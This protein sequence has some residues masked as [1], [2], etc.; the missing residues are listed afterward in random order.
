MQGKARVDSQ[1][2]YHQARRRTFLLV[3]C[4]MGSHLPCRQLS[5]VRNA[6]HLAVNESSCSR[7]DA[8]SQK[9][10]VVI[11]TGT[12]RGPGVRLHAATTDRFLLRMKHYQGCHAHAIPDNLIVSGAKQILFFV[13]RQRLALEVLGLA[14][15]VSRVISC[16]ARCAVRYIDSI[17]CSL[18]YSACVII[19]TNQQVISIISTN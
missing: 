9:S 4:L 6:H 10:A 13:H 1:R 5:Q 16:M 15:K 8:G 18:T 14:R 7:A 17:A 2:R 12:K 11:A 19:S 3:R